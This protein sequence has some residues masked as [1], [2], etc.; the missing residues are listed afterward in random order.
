MFDLGFEG[1]DVGGGI[2]LL[3]GEDAVNERFDCW[4]LLNNQLPTYLSS[5]PSRSAN[6]RLSRLAPLLT[7]SRSVSCLDQLIAPGGDGRQEI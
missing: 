4:L 7:S 2:G 5:Q 1:L 3:G 6:S